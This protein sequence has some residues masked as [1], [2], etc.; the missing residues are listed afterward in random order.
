MNNSNRNSL[1]QDV[2]VLRHEKFQMR[3]EEAGHA[4]NDPL[5]QP[6]DHNNASPNTFVAFILKRNNRLNKALG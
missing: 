6:Y 5:N 2:A 3:R 4:A 1:V